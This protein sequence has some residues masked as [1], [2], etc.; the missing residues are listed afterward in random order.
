MAR[1]K[2]YK[3]AHWY[4]TLGLL[5][6]LVGFSKT[7]FTKLGDFGFAH[8]LHGVSATLWMLLLIVQ[9]YLF[10]KD[11][12]KMLNVSTATIT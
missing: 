6:V 10:Q 4:L 5:I 9:P 11:Y 1:S 3:Y 12:L 8:H 7:Y 2:Y